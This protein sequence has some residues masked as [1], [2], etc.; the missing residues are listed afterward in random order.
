VT[1]KRTALVTCARVGTDDP[2]VLKPG[3][4]TDKRCAQ[5][6]AL[7]W[8]SPTTLAMEPE[9]DLIFACNPCGQAMEQLANQWNKPL[10]HLIA[11]GALRDDTP[12]DRRRRNELEAHGFRDLVKEDL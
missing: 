7:L 8:V 1:G 12:A 2:R 9:M 3:V 10:D 11:P 5:C 4:T 6:R